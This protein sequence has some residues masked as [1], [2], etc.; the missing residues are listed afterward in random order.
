VGTQA[1]RILAQERTSRQDSTR[2][3]SGH[4]R[5]RVLFAFMPTPNEGKQREDRGILFIFRRFCKMSTTRDTRAR[6]RL[7]L[8]YRHRIFDALPIC[9]FIDR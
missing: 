1:L 6:R 2:L 3:S 9:Q 5:R 7:R 8:H 4:S